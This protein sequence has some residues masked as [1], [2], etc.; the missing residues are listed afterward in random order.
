LAAHLSGDVPAFF[1]DY[2]IGHEILWAF[3]PF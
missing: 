3:K 2:S 1:M